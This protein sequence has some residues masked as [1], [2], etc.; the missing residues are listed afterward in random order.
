MLYPAFLARNRMVTCVLAKTT[1][2]KNSFIYGK[3]KFKRILSCLFGGKVQ[4]TNLL[5]RTSSLLSVL[6]RTRSAQRLSRQHFAALPSPNI[7]QLVPSGFFLST[8]MVSA[9]ARTQ[10]PRK[11]T[12]IF[13][14]TG[15]FSREKK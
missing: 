4:V 7:A 5:S 3:E 14:S 1:K 10:L 13:M 6:L 8:T 12:S 11:N 2:V 9:A 15:I